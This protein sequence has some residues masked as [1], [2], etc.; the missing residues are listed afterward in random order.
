MSTVRV[1]WCNPNCERKWLQW[2]G[3]VSE[4]HMAVVIWCGIRVAALRHKPVWR[5]IRSP[6]AHDWSELSGLGIRLVSIL[7]KRMVAFV[8]LRRVNVAVNCKTY[9]NREEV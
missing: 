2:T 6:G 7:L 1:G 3:Q 8:N 4:H 5:L 9:C